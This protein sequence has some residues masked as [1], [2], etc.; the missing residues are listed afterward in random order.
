MDRVILDQALLRARWQML[1][2]GTAGKIG[3]GLLAFSV[4]FF[5]FMSVPRRCR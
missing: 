1:R 2:L 3:I 5:I 4:V